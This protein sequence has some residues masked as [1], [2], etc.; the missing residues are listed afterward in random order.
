MKDRTKE[1]AWQKANREKK[2]QLL[3]NYL[4]EHPCID[5]GMANPI[6][7]EFDHVRGI[8]KFE[9]GKAVTGSGRSWETIL[10]EIAKC[11]VRCRNCHAIQTFQRQNS[12]KCQMILDAS[13]E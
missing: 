11:D 4:L 1:Y 10:T 12:W 7:L 6:V 2:K 8:K 3:W 5:C 9:I 13:V